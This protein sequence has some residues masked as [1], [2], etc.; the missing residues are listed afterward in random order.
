MSN[1]GE[2]GCED[3]PLAAEEE[4]RVSLYL[5]FKQYFV[6][7]S[8]YFV[9][10]YLYISSSNSI[11]F[12]Y[13][14]I[15]SSNSILFGYHVSKQWISSQWIQNGC[16]CYYCIF[17]DVSLMWFWSKSYFSKLATAIL[18]PIILAACCRRDLDPTYLIINRIIFRRLG[19]LSV[20][21]S[22]PTLSRQCISRA[23]RR[24]KAWTSPSCQE[25][26]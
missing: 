17:S 25:R 5:V 7:L 19:A 6:R 3:G 9:F 1:C 10:E 26:L 18:I 12:G 16:C 2:S 23:A 22:P 21:R 13:L 11:L 24:K 4:E 8:L 15:S 14:Y 20:A